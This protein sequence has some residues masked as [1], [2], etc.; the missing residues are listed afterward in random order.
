MSDTSISNK[1]Q[2]EGKELKP[3]DLSPYTLIKPTM[4][5]EEIRM[6]KEVEAIMLDDRVPTIEQQEEIKRKYPAKIWSSYF[7]LCFNVP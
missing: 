7:G 3:S 6:R 2:E 1:G 4:P 5:A